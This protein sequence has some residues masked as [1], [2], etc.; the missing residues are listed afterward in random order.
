MNN[1]AIPIHL[2]VGNAIARKLVAAWPACAKENIDG[3]IRTAI[4][5]YRKP[6]AEEYRRTA[7]MLLKT[8][9]C[10]LDEKKNGAIDEYVAKYLNALA[11][12]ELGIKGTGKK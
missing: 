1:D 10:Y 5:D 4:A 12:K 2:V 3:W 11:L 6:L 7:E 8:G 9:I